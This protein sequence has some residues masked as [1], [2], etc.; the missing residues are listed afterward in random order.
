MLSNLRFAFRS[1]FFAHTYSLLKPV[2]GEI[3][4]KPNKKSYDILI[5]FIISVYIHEYVY[6]L[7]VIYYIVVHQMKRQN[8]HAFYLEYENKK[9][10][11]PT[12]FLRDKYISVGNWLLDLFENIWGMIPDRRWLYHIR[13]CIFFLDFIILGYALTH[14]WAII[15]SSAEYRSFTER[16]CVCVCMCVYKIRHFLFFPFFFSFF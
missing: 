12:E 15:F 4:V 13:L 7:F 2:P 6:F 14:T 16:K 10:I 9:F 3:K 1:F 5:Y 11:M 8:L